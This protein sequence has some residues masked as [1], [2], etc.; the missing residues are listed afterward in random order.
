MFKNDLI[1]KLVAPIGASA[2]LCLILA[3]FFPWQGFFVNLGT[4]LIGTLITV[5][6][7]DAVLTQNEKK[8]WEKTRV[9]LAARIERVGNLAITGLRLAC[10]FHVD[11]IPMIGQTDDGKILRQ[12]MVKFTEEILIPSLPQKMNGLNSTEW[13]KLL[14]HMNHV[15]LEADQVVNLFGSHV[16]PRILECILEIRSKADS[17]LAAHQLV[18]E[19]FGTPDNQF[20]LPSNATLADKRSFYRIVTKDLEE[21]LVAS[22]TLLR[23]LS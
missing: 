21:S 17:I 20:P 15:A 22:C 13:Q 11:M 4:T 9:H 7:V 19:I 10:K 12:S 3:Y 16:E 5:F 14:Q 2:I 8:Q 23:R 1:Y 18:P 6:Y